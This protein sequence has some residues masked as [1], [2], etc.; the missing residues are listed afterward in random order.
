[1]RRFA[2]IERVA[3]RKLCMIDGADGLGD[4]QSIG[5]R[6]ESLKGKRRGYYSVRVNDKW[7][8]C[9]KWVDG[10]AYEGMVVDCH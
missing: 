1:M 6:L 2:A 3:L 7:R 4:L 10:N 8:I 9:F 5:N